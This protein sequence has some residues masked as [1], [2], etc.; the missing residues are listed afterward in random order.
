MLYKRGAR[1]GCDRLHNLC[2]QNVS[3]THTIGV[4]QDAGWGSHFVHTEQWVS[5]APIHR[6]LLK[7]M[8]T[9]AFSNKGKTTTSYRPDQKIHWCRCQER[10]RER[11]WGG[12]GRRKES[13]SSRQNDRGGEETHTEGPVPFLIFTLL[14]PRHEGGVVE[15]YP[16]RNGTPLQEQVT[17]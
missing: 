10:G 16:L 4:R 9:S 15:I 1:W 13:A 8:D 2:P 6:L 5:S 14:A 3:N 17:S 12:R 11:T 7:E